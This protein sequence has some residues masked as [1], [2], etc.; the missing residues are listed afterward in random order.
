MS[1]SPTET[2]R[3]DITPGEL[4]LRDALADHGE[5]LA[6]ALEHTDQLEAILETAVL[7]I[8]SADEDDVDEITDS[9]V[10]LIEAVDGLA[11]EQSVALADAIGEHGEDAASALETVLRLERN[12]SLDELVT[13]AETLSDLSMDDDA[14]RGLNRLMRAVGEA[15][16][17]SEPVGLLGA[18]RAMRTA[19]ARTGLGY[20]LAIVREQGRSLR[21]DGQR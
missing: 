11:T 21:G 16:A 10:S 4:A 20:L 17:D 15:E 19:D 9:I 6:A 1:E 18:L 5:D 3:E 12:G 7:V 8:A 13:L 2:T 14:V